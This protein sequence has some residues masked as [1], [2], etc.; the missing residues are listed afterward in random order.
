MAMQRIHAILRLFVFAILMAGLIWPAISYSEVSA[1]P[2]ATF[3][4]DDTSDLVDDN[5]GDGI[6]HTA[7]DTCTLRAAIQSANLSSNVDTIALQGGVLYML[8]R[9]G[10]DEDN[11]STGDL[12]IKYRVTINGNGSTIDAAGLAD[13]IFDIRDTVTI[14]D[15]I[16]QNGTV[17]S[18]YGGGI[19]FYTSVSA[20]ALTLNNVTVQNNSSDSGTGGVYMA[21]N[22]YNASISGCDINHNTGGG[23]CF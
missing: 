22:Y 3:T 19:Y 9:S 10:A 8:T 5:V 20:K 23:I 16:I 21:G 12:D 17:T 7:N 2:E 4:V 1:E 6:C 11:A 13:R 15:L 18:G 14:N